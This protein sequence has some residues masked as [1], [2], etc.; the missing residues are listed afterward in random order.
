MT[1]RRARR[2]LP[3]PSVDSVVATLGVV[4]LGAVVFL[5]VQHLGHRPEEA[6]APGK[7]DW[8]SFQQRVDA[9][10]VRLEQSALQLPAA[11]V[12]PQG[13]GTMRWLHRRYEITVPADARDRVRSVMEA[14]R[15]Q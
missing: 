5:T 2:R 10:T 3:I 6:P 14:A 11:T 15:G 12:Q 13:S 9:V 8:Q 4:A 1:R 7:E